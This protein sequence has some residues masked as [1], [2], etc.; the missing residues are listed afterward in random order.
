MNE[1]ILKGKKQ[2]DLVG[3]VGVEQAENLYELLMSNPKARINLDQCTHLHAALLQ[4][5]IL[6]KPY[7]MKP[8]NEPFLAEVLK[9][10]GLVRG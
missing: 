3:H 1:V 2:I 10:L 9:D 7:I 6:R 5:L 4:V 8:V